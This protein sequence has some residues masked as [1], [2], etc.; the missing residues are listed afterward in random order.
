LAEHEE[1]EQKTEEATPRR[2]EEAREKGQVA[3]SS[4]LVAALAMCAGL[5]A[6][7]LGGGRLAEDVGRLV[8]T[9]VRSMS[10]LGTPAFTPE[11]A[12]ALIEASLLSVVTSLGLV[13]LPVVAIAG[14]ASYLQVGFRVTPKA[15]ELDPSKISPVQGARRLFGARALVRT[16]LAAVKVIAI[17]A[18]VVALG[19]SQVPGIVRLGSSELGPL[20]A[21][22]VRVALRCTA[23]ALGVVLALSLLDL[24]FQ[25]FQHGR[26]MRM[27]RQ[28]IKEEHRMAEGDPHVRARMRQIQREMATRRMMTA[29][30]KAT[31]VVTNPTHYAVALRYDRS[32]SESTAPVVVAKGVDHL[33]ARIREVAAAAGVPRHEDVALARALHAQ[34]D[35]GQEIP[36]ELFAAVAAVLGHV[37]RLQGL[38]TAASVPAEVAG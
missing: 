7:A 28:E 9:S 33:A 34:V 25:R 14:A 21:G 32:A 1:K 37:Y 10:A 18:T 2:L 24:A 16:A 36:A 27:S 13:V 30:P 5:G 3:L 6:L 38:A 31:V 17:T 15:I 35:V 26:D 4:E 11:T 23:G 8:E 20:L 19:W 29:V 12:A 22:L